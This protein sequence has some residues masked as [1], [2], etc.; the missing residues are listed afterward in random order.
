MK[1]T[2]KHTQT[3]TQQ[4]MIRV[5]SRQHKDEIKLAKTQAELDLTQNISTLRKEERLTECEERHHIANIAAVTKN[6]CLTNTEV[7]LLGLS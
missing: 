2:H 5:G 3:K 4:R 7:A 1:T 6:V